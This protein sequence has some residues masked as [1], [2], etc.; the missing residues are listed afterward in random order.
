MVDGAS[1]PGKAARTGEL[2]PSEACGY[3]ALT[4]LPELPLPMASDLSEH[5][6]TTPRYQ[7]GGE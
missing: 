2:T 6:E 4:P 1:G 3:H 5:I 7:T